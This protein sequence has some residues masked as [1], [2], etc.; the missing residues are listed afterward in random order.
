MNYK[1]AFNSFLAVSC[2]SITYYLGGWDSVMKILALFI[3]LDYVT[4]IMKGFWNKE[5]AS[6]V[7]FKGIMKKAAIFIVVIVANQL[8]LAIPQENP[9]F[10]TLACYFYIANE[11]ISILENIALMGVQLPAPIFD[12]LKKLKE[13]K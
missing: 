2:T 7:G 13:S 6:D 11:G 5:L 9:V 3:V 12:A 4:G 8:D 10:R 1:S